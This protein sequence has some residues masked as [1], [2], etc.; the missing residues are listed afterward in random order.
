MNHLRSCIVVIFNH[1]TKI[2]IELFVSAQYREDLRGS[3]SYFLFICL[4]FTVLWSWFCYWKFL[5]SQNT[6]VLIENSQNWPHL[7][8]WA[9]EQGQ[10]TQDQVS[11]TARVECPEL[12]SGVSTLDQFSFST[13]NTSFP[14][15]HLISSQ[16]SSLLFHIFIWSLEIFD[17]L[18]VESGDFIK[19]RLF[20][21]KKTFTSQVFRLAAS[22]PTTPPASNV[23][24]LTG[25]WS[26]CCTL[27]T[28]KGAQEQPCSWSIGLVL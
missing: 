15:F 28:S 2:A 10:H 1:K 26:C 19:T 3:S 24:Q 4:I 25:T 6:S 12:L 22:P 9:E 5:K 8:V 11:C 27:K 14:V 20:H 16:F 21:N 13:S 23:H 7:Q 17:S 18:L